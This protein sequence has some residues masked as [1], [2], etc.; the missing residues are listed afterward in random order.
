MSSFSIRSSTI[1]LGIFISTLVIAAILI[2]QLIWL[3]KVYHREQ[4]EFD[5]G[6]IKAI[7]G[8]YEDI[9][10]SAYY[11]S[12]LNEL[13]ENPE[14]HLYLAHITLPVNKDSL[15]SYLQYELE[16]FDIFT[17]CYLGIYKA[18]SG[19]YIYSRI[20]QTAAGKKR[21]DIS[22]PV[23]SRKYD[24][25]TLY[26]PNRRQY[27][28]GRM[29]FWIFSSAVLLLVLILFGGS[30]Y[31]FYKQKF[32]NETQNDF[33]HNFTHEF[34]TPVSVISLAADVLEDPNN[35][36]KPGKLATYAGI[37]KYQAEYLQ[38]QT[39]KLLN[40]A[41]TES[42]QLHFSKENVN[43]HELIQEAVSNL[44]PLISEKN[45]QITLGLNAEQPFL[46]ANK[47]YLVIVII[48]LLD[49]A[50]KYS[51]QPCISIYTKNI[52]NRMILSVSDNGVGIEKKQISKLFRKFFR[53][54]VGETYVAKGFGLGLS[55]VKKIVT[56]HKGRIKVE[57]MPGKGSNFIIELPLQ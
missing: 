4:K 36:Q 48:N 26:F 25:L 7:G 24:H 12:H 32:L 11:S 56:A 57:S 52:G 34:K 28:L 42:R 22:I 49:N 16:D 5:Q 33:I 47:D 38:K 8:L 19:K 2:F 35:A 27:I 14:P 13:I 6:V 30:L 41:Y 20:L 15:V 9:N 46:L 21:S 55:F 29:N 45:A 51:K 1:R 53:G 17:D 31:Y 44:A 39:E 40:F 50:I 43:I 3:K 37:V 23:L 18:D 54:Q 10:A